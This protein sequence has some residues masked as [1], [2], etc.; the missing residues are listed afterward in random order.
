[1]MLELRS[2]I[3]IG[4]MAGTGVAG[5][6]SAAPGRIVTECAGSWAEAGIATDATDN[7]AST[8]TKNRG[9]RTR[10]DLMARLLAQG[11]V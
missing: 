5:A 4:E 3:R 8:T 9:S 10:D 1:L 11:A 2:S 7:P 6:V